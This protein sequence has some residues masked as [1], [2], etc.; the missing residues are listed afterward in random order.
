MK[1]VF[2]TIVILVS[3]FGLKGIPSTMATHRKARTKSHGCSCRIIQESLNYPFPGDQ[4]KCKCLV[5]L[6]DFTFTFE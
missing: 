2:E 6:K 4:Q 1:N 3:R 5:I